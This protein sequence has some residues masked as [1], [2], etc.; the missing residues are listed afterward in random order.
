MHATLLVLNP[1]AGRGRL[2]RWVRAQAAALVRSRPG[3]AL[4]ESEDP[5][6]A[7]RAVRAL[8]PGSRVIV[9]G[10]DGSVQRLLA[11]LVDGGH[12]LALLP[13]GHG[14]DLA[15][16]MGLRGLRPAAALRRALHGRAL[17]LDLGCVTPLDPAGTPAWFASSLCAGLD[18]AIAARAARDSAT[19]LPGALR[20]LRATWQEIRQLRPVHLQLRADGRPVHDGDALFAAVLNTATYGAG[21]RAAP[22][23]QPDDGQL[24][25]VVAGAFTRWGVLGML[26]RLMLGRHGG[27]PRV[28]LLPVEVLQAQAA[29]P[30]PLAADGEP[31]PPARAWRVQVHAQALRAVRAH[32]EG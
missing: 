7:E 9:A 31:L 29:E 24:D 3:L 20:Y 25:L 21:L 1:R 23:A 14:D 4:H 17:P 16:A 19:A 28:R 26:P 11:A 15:R 27:H 2:A 12:E 8:P 6:S 30:L 32:D 5:A 13:G 22:R 18:A 10:G